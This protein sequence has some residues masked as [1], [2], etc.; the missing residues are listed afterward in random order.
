MI[1]QI[2]TITI[3]SLIMLGAVIYGISESGSPFET[4]NKKFDAQRISDLSNISYA[5]E[6]YYQKSNKLP[7][8]LKEVT[9]DSTY[10][11]VSKN[12]KDPET[13]A[14][15]QYTAG[16]SSD[17]QLCADFST[18]NTKVSDEPRL[19][20]VYDYSYTDKKWQHPK[21]NYCFKLNANSALVPPAPING[22]STKQNTPN[23]V[24]ELTKRSRDAYRLSDLANLQQAINVTYQ[25]ATSTA[26]VLCMGGVAK[27]G[28]TGRSLDTSSNNRSAAGTGWIKVNLQ[29][30]KAVGVPILPVDPVNSGIYHYTYCSDGGSKWEIDAALESSQQSPKVVSDGGNDNAVYEVGSDLTIIGAGGICTY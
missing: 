9:E 27:E 19:G 4:R 8:D 28:C 23:D 15:Y 7:K 22:E 10:S 17:Y 13:K 21:G 5:I 30:Q 18:D 2:I 14:D 29:A 3:L 26:S 25:E 11:Y 1:K 16:A 6:S 24:S 20:Q 12:T